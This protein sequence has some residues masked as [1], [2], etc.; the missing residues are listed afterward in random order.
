[1][2]IDS[3]EVRNSIIQKIKDKN[4][5]TD[6]DIEYIEV[7][8]ILLDEGFAIEK[9]EDDL[10]PSILSNRLYDQLNNLMQYENPI[11]C[12]IIDNLWKTFY[13]SKSN[14]IHSSYRGMLTT[15]AVSYPKLKIFEFRD[16]DEFVEFVVGLDK[17]IHKEGASVRPTPMVRKPRTPEQIKE[18]VLSMIPGLGIP[19]SQKL[20]EYFGS[21]KNIANAS[22]EELQKVEK[23]GPKLAKKIFD[24]LH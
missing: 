13:F 11:L 6:V 18:N 15:L 17:K 14:W 10:I 19:K 23:I 5:V 4:P 8:D 3:R 1:M 20:L 9:K 21:V 22:E 24:S 16:E 12:I 2:I 7:A